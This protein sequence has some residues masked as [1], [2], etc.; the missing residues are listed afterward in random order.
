[1]KQQDLRIAIKKIV[2]KKFKTL[3]EKESV[4]ASIRSHLEENPIDIKIIRQY[5]VTE[6]FPRKLMIDSF[7]DNWY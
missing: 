2:Y 4:I 1:M 6:I 7:K 5:G 3:A